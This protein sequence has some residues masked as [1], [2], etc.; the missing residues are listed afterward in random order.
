MNKQLKHCLEKSIQKEF[1]SVCHNYD[2]RE[3]I[4]TIPYNATLAS[5]SVKL[6]LI[7]AT[8]LDYDDT[9]DA[10]NP[11]D[12]DKMAWYLIADDN[13]TFALTSSHFINKQGVLM[14]HYM[15]DFNGEILYQK[16]CAS[17]K[18]VRKNPILQLMRKCSD[19]LIAQERAAQ[20]HKMEKMFISTNM[21]IPSAQHGRM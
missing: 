6:A 14:T 9:F 11:H 7:R 5:R 21:F 18:L 8:G 15:L 3:T 10:N 20:E 1:V 16:S 12:I 19:K 2:T 13:P 17:D 4:Y